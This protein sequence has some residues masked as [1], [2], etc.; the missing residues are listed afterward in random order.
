MKLIFLLAICIVCSLAPTPAELAATVTK[1]V[2]SNAS[3][4]LVWDYGG[5]V[6][7]DSFW[8]FADYFKLADLVTPLNNL[9]DSFTTNTNQ[10]GYKI[11]H[12]IS[13]PMGGAVGDSVGLYPISY[14]ARAAYYHAHPDS[15]Y[16][17][18]TDLKIAEIV[19]NQYILGWPHHLSDGTISRTSGWSGEPAGSQFLWDDDMYMG[20][21]LISRVAVLQKNSTLADIAGKMQVTFAAH[22]LDSGSSL[23]WHGFN[24]EDQ[25]HSCCKWG[26][27]NGWLMMSH[28]EVLKALKA[29]N[30]NQ[31][32][33]QVISLLQAHSKALMNVQSSNG[34]WHQLVDQESTFLETSATAMYLW[35]IAEGISGG[36]LDKA[37][38]GPVVEK[39]WNGL[40][41]TINANGQVSGVCEGT[42]I[43]NTV[44]F[45]A[46]RSTSYLSSSPGLGSVFKAI[47]AYARYAASK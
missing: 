18:E 36:W 3:H 23:F 5:A 8:E 7:T 32:Y 12:G 29:T 21:T 13:I 47:T 31:Y 20:L 10:D 39:A 35:S 44:Q 40:Q 45:Y 1:P 30:N 9:L 27:G 24:N 11:L 34:L 33:S 4:F 42:G 22:V 37:V 6:I 17:N 19:S 26:R 41:T 25:H 28:I 43:G 16:N 46:Q 38:Y 2:F 14:L 15:K